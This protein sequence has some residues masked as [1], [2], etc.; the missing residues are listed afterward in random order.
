MLLLPLPLLLLL[1][2]LNLLVVFPGALPLASAGVGGYIYIYNMFI[3][4]SVFF[5]IKMAI[6]WFISKKN[7]WQ[8]RQT[9][10]K[11]QDRAVVMQLIKEVAPSGCH[12]GWLR[13]EQLTEAARS[14]RWHLI[15]PLVAI[16][17][18][19]ETR[20]LSPLVTLVL[21]RKATSAF[22]LAVVLLWL[23]GFLVFKIATWQL[24]SLA[25]RCHRGSWGFV[26][27]SPGAETAQLLRM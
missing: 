10:W 22:G 1:V 21:V 13:H 8:T 3:L 7:I 25:G 12:Q 24:D 27:W 5:H 16:L 6:K 19:L 9:Q 2:R 15:L 20:C 23:V 4:F 11:L 17:S 14:A 18:R 26:L